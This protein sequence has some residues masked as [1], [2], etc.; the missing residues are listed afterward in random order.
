LTVFAIFHP[1]QTHT[2]AKLKSPKK[3]PSEAR[4]TPFRPQ[5]QRPT[6]KT[7]FY[8]D[9]IRLY[10]YN[11]DKLRAKRELAYRGD[12]KS[13]PG[14]MAIRVIAVQRKN[15]M[16]KA[17][18]M[19][20]AVVL[21]VLPIYLSGCSQPGETVAEGHR[22]HI[23]NLSVNQQSLMKDIDSLLLFEEPSSL[24]DRKIE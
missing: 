16:K 10:R 5:T 6:P 21:F 23:R 20:L 24:S 19:I 8:V 14:R 12:V 7:L 3:T 2:Y 22:R 17:V 15:M 9:I 13:N 4:T 18:L 11:G 1:I